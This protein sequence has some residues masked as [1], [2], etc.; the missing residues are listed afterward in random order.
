MARLYL[1]S[2]REKEKEGKG[3]N[4]MTYKINRKVLEEQKGKDVG[5]A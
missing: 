1:S 5:P 3:R 4:K 2:D